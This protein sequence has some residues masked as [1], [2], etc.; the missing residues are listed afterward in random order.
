M[1]A[2]EQPLEAPCFPAGR[3]GLSVAE[4]TRSV[5]QAEATVRWTPHGTPGAQPGQGPLEQ[6]SP[7]GGCGRAG[8]TPSPSAKGVGENLMVLVF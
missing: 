5:S 1:W 2:Q 7:S 3:A 6:G 8:T 4:V